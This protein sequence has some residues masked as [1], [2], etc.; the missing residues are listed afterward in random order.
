MLVGNHEH[1]FVRCV[2]RMLNHTRR[3]AE[4]GRPARRHNCHG[5]QYDLVSAAEL[6]WLHGRPLSVP[7]PELGVL[8]VHAGL[9]P[10]VPLRAQRTQDLLT[11]RSL[12]PDGRASSL[13]GNESWASRWAGPEH[14]IFGHDA[15]RRLQRHRFATGIDTGV[16]YGGQLSALVLPGRQLVQV[17]AKAVWCVPKEEGVGSAERSLS[18]NCQLKKQHTPARTVVD[19]GGRAGVGGAARRTT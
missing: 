15:R 18:P 11:I 2:D 8:L 10:G 6:A 1:G 4:R 9:R 19:G 17:A 7:L 13:S 3:R 12:A 16:V 14:V 5:I